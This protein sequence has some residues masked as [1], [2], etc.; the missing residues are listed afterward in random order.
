[1]A[2]V[3]AAASESSGGDG[4]VDVTG[5]SRPRSRNHRALSSSEEDGDE[6]NTQVMV[7]DSNEDEDYDAAVAL[8]SCHVKAET[9]DDD[10]MASPPRK[11]LRLLPITPAGEERKKGQKPGVS[12]EHSATLATVTASRSPAKSNAAQA[13]Q[14]HMRDEANSPIRSSTTLLASGLPPVVGL[15]PSLNSGSQSRSIKT[16]DAVLEE[17][18]YIHEQIPRGALGN[19]ALAFLAD[20]PAV[21]GALALSKK[22]VYGGSAVVFQINGNKASRLQNLKA[23]MAQAA[24]IESP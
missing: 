21:D 6:S 22:R 3:Q 12:T 7:E 4:G 20:Q 23:A 18:P 17:F 24:G 8:E 5:P 14:L 9:E 13:L 11:R 16:W 19:A 15:N 1:M 10:S 2:S